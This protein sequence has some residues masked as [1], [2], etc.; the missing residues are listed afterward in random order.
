MRYEQAIQTIVTKEEVKKEIRLHGLRFR[1]FAEDLGN[2]PNYSGLEVLN[3]LG[4]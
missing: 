4:Y 3:W 2:K 1:D